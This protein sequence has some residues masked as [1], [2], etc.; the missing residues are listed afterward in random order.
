MSLSEICAQ[1]HEYEQTQLKRLLLWGLL[2]SFGVHG[3]ALGL[4]QAKPWP[5]AKDDLTPIQLIAADP[6]TDPVPDQPTAWSESTQP[7]PQPR[8]PAVTTTASRP[9]ATMSPPAAVMPLVAPVAPDRSQPDER[10][11]AESAPEPSPANAGQGA[12]RSAA[13]AIE[14]PP[15]GVQ[16]ETAATEPTESQAEG[17]GDNLGQR[18]PGADPGPSTVAVADRA[19]R[20]ALPNSSTGHSP[21][22]A[23]GP[24]T[25][26][27]NGNSQNSQGSRAVTCQNCVR[28]TYPQSALDARVEGQPMVRVDI[29]PDG[30]VRRV[31][32]TR[33]SGHGAIDRA[34][35]EAARN[36]RFHPI[37]G[38]ATVPIEYDLTIEGSHRNRD[39]RRRGERQAVDLPPGPPP[40]APSQTN[41]RSALEPVPA[42]G[43]PAPA[44]PSPISPPDPALPESPSPASTVPPPDSPA[45]ESAE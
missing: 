35:I 18:P 33:S 20:A 30:T 26:Q 45:A 3:L 6:L 22:T 25:P 41:P 34:A 19:G 15:D 23:T 12:I 44:A 39:A 14:A 10:S 2:G 13:E 5:M 29:N 16:P 27:G 4:S 9:G 21:A 32:L 24:S 36:S 31:T 38:G 17:L 7:S 43:E 37:A 11:K 40:R 1:Q 8:H 28:P 42:A